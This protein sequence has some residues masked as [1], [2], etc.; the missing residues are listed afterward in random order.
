MTPRKISVKRKA[1]RWP[2]LVEGA[3]VLLALAAVQL[4][5]AKTVDSDELSRTWQSAV[6]YAIG[7][8]VSL[9]ANRG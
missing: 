8:G 9:F 3:F 7:R 4:V 6:V 1:P 2:A 5:N